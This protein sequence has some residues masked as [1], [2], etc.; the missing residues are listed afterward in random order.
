MESKRVGRPVLR[1]N[2]VNDSTAFHGV[3][4]KGPA[5]G[6]PCFEDLRHRCAPVSPRGNLAQNLAGLGDRR[7]IAGRACDSGEGSPPTVQEAQ[8]LDAGLQQVLAVL[9]NQVRHGN[10][11]DEREISHV[12]LHCTLA[13]AESPRSWANFPIRRSPGSWAD[14]GNRILA[15]FGLMSAAVNRLV[16]F[17]HAQQGRVLRQL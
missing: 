16:P 13:K 3:F 10:L 17:T 8:P 9:K 7:E 2:I 5:K 15:D 1:G 14:D 6:L 12:Q 11:R 4:L